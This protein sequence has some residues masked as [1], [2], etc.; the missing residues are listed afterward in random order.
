[1]DITE[2]R[3]IYPVLAELTACLCAAL[4]ESRPCFCGLLVGDEIPAEYVGECADDDGEPSCGAAYV[5]LVTAYP[6]E[7]FPDAL[8]RPTCNS[9]MAYQVAVGVLRCISI[10]EDDGSPIDP[11][12]LKANALLRLGDM[13]AMRRA[14][15]CCFGR[16]FDDVEHVMGVYTPLP[17]TGDIVGGEWMVTIS[18][19][20]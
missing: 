1:M 12:E 6:T 7:N 2:D 20:F 17:Q 8:E 14:I 15:Q 16:A 9:V 10:G 4:G 13:K 3:G 11:E 5:R 18:E 19:V